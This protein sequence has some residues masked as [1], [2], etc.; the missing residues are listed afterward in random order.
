MGG[1]GLWVL[2]QFVF[3]EEMDL[4]VWIF[5]KMFCFCFGVWFIQSLVWEFRGFWDLQFLFVVLGVVMIL[6]LDYI[7][8]GV[9]W[10]I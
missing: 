4:K 2:N 7:V 1:F 10:F 5:C 3:C 9:F 6:D 8:Q